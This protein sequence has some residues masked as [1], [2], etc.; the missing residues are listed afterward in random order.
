[1]DRVQAVLGQPVGEALPDEAGHPH[2]VPGQDLVEL[3]RG[4]PRSRSVI[5]HSLS[6]RCKP[7]LSVTEILLLRRRFP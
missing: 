1:M 7:L 4:P 3:V 6:L 5:R 2:D